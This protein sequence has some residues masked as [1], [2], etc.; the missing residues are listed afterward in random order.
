MFK[1]VAKFLKRVRVQ[2]QGERGAIITVPKS[3]RNE[4]DLDS[5]KELDIWQMGRMLIIFPTKKSTE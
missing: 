2:K 4:F 5:G 3:Y 1:G